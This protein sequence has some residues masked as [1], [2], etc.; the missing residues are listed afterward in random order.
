MFF[1][2]SNPQAIISTTIENGYDSLNSIYTGLG[3]SKLKLKAD[4][5]RISFK[6]TNPLYIKKSVFFSR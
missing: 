6:F 4:A 2:H 1:P 5:E 3:Y